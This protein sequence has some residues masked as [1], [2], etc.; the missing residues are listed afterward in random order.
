[1][2]AFN[3]GSRLLRFPKLQYTVSTIY[4]L[5]VISM[6]A[7]HTKFLK[8]HFGW[9]LQQSNLVKAGV[10]LNIFPFISLFVRSVNGVIYEECI[11]FSITFFIF[12]RSR[13]SLKCGYM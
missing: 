8:V 12:L 4:Q 10:A 9:F 5:I 7:L 1:M 2:V 3:Y 11:I 6:F 13:G